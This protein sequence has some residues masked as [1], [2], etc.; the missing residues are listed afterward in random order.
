MNIPRGFKNS[1]PKWQAT[2]YIQHISRKWEVLF[3]TSVRFPFIQSLFYSTTCR[4]SVLG[5][6]STY[7]STCFNP[8]DCLSKDCSNWNQWQNNVQSFFKTTNWPSPFLRPTADRYSDPWGTESVWREWDD[9]RYG[10]S[11]TMANKWRANPA[12]WYAIKLVLN[13]SKAQRAH[14]MLFI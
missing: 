12:I 14:T 8:L 3:W 5:L 11:G 10:Q 9:L 2:L 4:P 7:A 13:N 6:Y 1:M